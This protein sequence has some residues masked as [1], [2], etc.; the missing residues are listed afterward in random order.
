VYDVT[1][2]VKYHPGGVEEI[3]KGAGQDATNMFN[4][5]HRWVNVESILKKNLLGFYVRHS[6]LTLEKILKVQATT[7]DSVSKKL[8]PKTKFSEDVDS[9]YFEVCR[10]RKCLVLLQ[11]DVF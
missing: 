1:E 9:L 6:T 2:Y 7:V 4:Q 10:E 11:Q 3:M 8:L 5:I